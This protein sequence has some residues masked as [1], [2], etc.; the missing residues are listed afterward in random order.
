MGDMV[1]HRP[2][3]DERVLQGQA[4][5]PCNRGKSA[6]AVDAPG[7]SRRR[8]PDLGPGEA[9]WR[10]LV[11]RAFSGA[12]SI[13]LLIPEVSCCGPPSARPSSRGWRG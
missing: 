12:T 13:A 5:A 6:T 3:P 10:F 11:G 2:G 7:S 8:W 1:V 4:Q 9:T